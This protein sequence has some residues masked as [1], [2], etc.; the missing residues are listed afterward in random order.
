MTLS[1]PIKLIGSPP[2]PYT[3][4]MI[5]IL[6]Y[7]RIP[8]SL[9][10]GDPAAELTKMGI[11]KPKIGFLPTFLLPDEAGALQ[12]VCDSTPIIRRLESE[13][14]GRS[15]IPTDAALAFI[16]YLLEDFAD[17]WCTKYMF[18][19]RW[20]FDEDADNA[21]TLLPLNHSG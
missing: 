20:H 4:K 15:V 21:G 7:R 14:E 6:R 3:R 11:A 1:L 19:Y 12:A 9:T 8:Y 16:D 18:H 5:S 13:I 10:W 17:E 2:S